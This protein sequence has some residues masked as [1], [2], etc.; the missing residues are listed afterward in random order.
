M[1]FDFRYYGKSSVQAGVSAT[2]MNFAPDTLREPAFFVGDLAHHIPFRE[3]MSALHDV[4]VGDL[5]YKPKNREEYYAWL[6]RQEEILLAEFMEGRETV[7]E[8]LDSVRKELSG[9]RE[10]QAH[11]LAPF[12]KAQ[13]KYF[14]Y[15][16]THDYNAWFVL[17]PVITIHPDEIFFECFSQDESS[18]GKL[19]CSLD[20]F[21]NISDFK[22]GTTNIDYSAQ[23]YGEF[24]KIRDYKTTRLAIDPSGFQIET[25]H[26]EMYSEQKIDL[27]E[28]WVRGFLQVSSA[29]TLPMV[30]FELHPMD[31]HNFCFV[32]RRQK[33]RSGP[34][35][36][37][38]ELVPDQ[39]V[40]AV[41]EPWNH[42][43]VC[44][45]SVYTGKETQEIRIW[46][47]R[48]L[49]MLE[50]L[51]P[52]AKRFVVSLL[53]TGMPS[54]F[55][56]DLGPMTFTLGLSGWTANDWSKVSNF[57]LMAPRARVDSQSVA[58]VL[59]ILEKEWFCASYDIAKT[60]QLD[61]RMVEAALGILAQQG[62]VIYDLKNQMYRLREL[63]REPLPFERLRFSNEREEKADTFIAKNLVK[64]TEST[65]EKGFLKL[66]GSVMDNAGEF[67]T[68][69]VIDPDQRLVEGR[70][71]CHF[72]VHNRLYKG[73]CEHMLALRRFY[74]AS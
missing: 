24:Q 70:C 69:L 54:F 20:V 30:S 35:S 60:M 12:L 40:K 16:Y 11:I 53:G 47:R 44:P 3:G 36:I 52:V 19:S 23:L 14:K 71:Q 27:P 4:V 26:E 66:S 17:D 9:I 21:K 38:F 5:R 15:L 62:R 51:I 25:S 59:G 68:G 56:A 34:R 48:R 33:E 8:K 67:N 7:R 63:S 72:Y 64:L 10:K 2:E 37:R 39:P 32:L 65:R 18:Y 29:M 46:G 49:F 50:R 58:G 28:S 31:I 45:R 61:Q 57:D 73:P 13:K 6:S 42:E 74:G 43:I 41:F 22:C 1:E 55:Q